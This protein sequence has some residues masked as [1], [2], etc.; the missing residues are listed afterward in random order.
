M[1]EGHMKGGKFHPHKNNTDS[2]VSSDQV[3]EKPQP[4]GINTSDAKKLKESKS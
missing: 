4:E 3:Q 2:G 1:A